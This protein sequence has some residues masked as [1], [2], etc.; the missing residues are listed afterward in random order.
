M[1]RLRRHSKG[2][3][4]RERSGDARIAPLIDNT[5]LHIRRG[6]GGGAGLG[7]PLWSPVLAYPLSITLKKERGGIHGRI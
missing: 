2:G 3:G 7:W 5:P 4:G 6:E 1:N